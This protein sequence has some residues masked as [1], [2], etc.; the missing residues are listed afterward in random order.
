MENKK[1]FFHSSRHFHKLKLF[2]VKNRAKSK[3]FS[4]NDFH[5]GGVPYFPMS[6]YEPKH[7][8]V[9]CN[10]HSTLD[11]CPKPSRKAT[12]VPYT[13]GLSRF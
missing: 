10:M 11:F 3:V 2:M 9:Q 4:K 1:H 12:N 5:E 8:S 7:H 6:A 13:P